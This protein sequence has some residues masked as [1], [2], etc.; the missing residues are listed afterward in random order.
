[1]SYCTPIKERLEVKLKAFDLHLV[2]Q[3][4]V[5]YLVTHDP[6]VENT[7][8]SP[9]LLEDLLP[10]LKEVSP[11]WESMSKEDLSTGYAAVNSMYHSVRSY[12]RSPTNLRGLVREFMDE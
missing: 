2:K 7:S 5:T 4:L 6:K 11:A 8:F 10:L 12:F 3:A 1:M 9:D